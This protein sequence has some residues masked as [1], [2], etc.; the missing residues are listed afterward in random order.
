MEGVRA[1]GREGVAAR[2]AP[3]VN[4]SPSPHV[5]TQTLV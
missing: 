3:V 5:N 1:G 2:T 4:A